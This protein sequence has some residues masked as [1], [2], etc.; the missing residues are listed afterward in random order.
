MNFED[1]VMDSARSH[2][3]NMSDPWRNDFSEDGQ[4]DDDFRYENRIN[5]LEEMFPDRTREEIEIAFEIIS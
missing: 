2:D 4:S 5:D 1:E 3:V